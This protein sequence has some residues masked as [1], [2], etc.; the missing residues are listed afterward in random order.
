MLKAK[1]QGVDENTIAKLDRR[2]LD[3]VTTFFKNKEAEI[4][5]SREGK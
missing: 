5:K 2:T 1:Q 3:E 4:R